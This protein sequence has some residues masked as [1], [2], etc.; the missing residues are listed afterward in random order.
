M[1]AAGFGLVHGFG[2]AGA[3]NEIGLPREAMVP[4]LAAFNIGVECGQVAIVLCAAPLLFWLA[5]KSKPAHYKFVI[6]GSCVIGTA[7]AFWLAQ[8]ALGL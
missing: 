6:A 3:L 8:R 1:L 2:F 4:A 5:R 7:G